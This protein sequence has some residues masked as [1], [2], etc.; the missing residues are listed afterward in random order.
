MASVTPT[1]ENASWMSSVPP[2][3]T[4]APQSRMSSRAG[5]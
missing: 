4:R 3:A 1:D 5:R 2:S